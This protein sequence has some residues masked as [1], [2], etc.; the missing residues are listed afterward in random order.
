MKTRSKQFYACNF[1][2]SQTSAIYPYCFPVLTLE[3]LEKKRK[4]KYCQVK[5]K[6]KYLEFIVLYSLTNFIIYQ[7]TRLHRISIF[8]S[9]VEP[10]LLVPR[11]FFQR[12]FYC[13]FSFLIG[14]SRIQTWLVESKRVDFFAPYLLRHNRSNTSHK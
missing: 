9:S 14:F 3:Y 10:C 8:L 5:T 11:K 6:S 1:V 4:K 2:L 12:F 13:F 7:D